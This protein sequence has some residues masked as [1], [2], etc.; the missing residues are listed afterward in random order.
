MQVRCAH[1]DTVMYPLANI[2]IQ[3]AGA[4]FT[5]KVA[6]SDWLLMLF[7]LGT[8]VQQLVELLN[9]FGQKTS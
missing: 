2:E 4:S 3:P 1:G 9:G 5:V 6:M 7:L 8:D